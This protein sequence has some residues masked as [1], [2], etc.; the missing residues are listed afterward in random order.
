MCAC[1]WRHFPGKLDHHMERIGRW[2]NAM[3]QKP[4]TPNRFASLNMFIL[5]LAV[6]CDPL[7]NRL[8]TRIFEA[9]NKNA[10]LSDGPFKA[11]CLQWPGYRLTL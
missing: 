1:P 3:L 7:V 2:D 11:C 5:V 8:A 4:D 9:V 6:D 10:V